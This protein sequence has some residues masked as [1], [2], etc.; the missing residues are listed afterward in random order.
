MSA[1]LAQFCPDLLL[2]GIRIQGG[3]EHLFAG[4]GLV[5]VDQPTVQSHI[6]DHLPFASA[7]RI[8]DVK[9]RHAV[10]DSH[11]DGMHFHAHKKHGPA[12]D[13]K[14]LLRRPEEIKINAIFICMT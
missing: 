11:D 9:D 8:R 14:R 2:V 5:D 1:D 7:L 3:A 6:T 4:I 10:S 12:V 13:G